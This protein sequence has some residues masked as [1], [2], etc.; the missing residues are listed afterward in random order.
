MIS[1]TAILSRDIELHAA[2][3]DG[4]TGATPAPT[5]PIAYCLPSRPPLARRAFT[6]LML[7]VVHS[8]ATTLPSKV[9]KQAE[10]LTSRLWPS[11]LC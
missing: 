10:K 4:H 11:C 3:P 8:P 5:P 7:C 9:V 6:L 2:V 1:T